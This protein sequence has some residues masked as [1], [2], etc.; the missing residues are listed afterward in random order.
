MSLNQI[1]DNGN[2]AEDWVN[3]RTHDLTVDNELKLANASIEKVD[4]T[5]NLMGAI[6]G[7]VDCE[8]RPVGKLIFVTLLQEVSLTSS[9]SSYITADNFPSEFIPTNN[10]TTSPVVV[11]DNGQQKVGS[12]NFFTPGNNI[13]FSSTN[14]NG[15]LGVF[16]GSGN[17]GF[18]GPTTFFYYL[19]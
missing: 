19:N 18:P 2:I 14:S 6:T 5:L 1:I 10:L 3:L 11:I 15:E 7:T 12:V 16:S 9:T 4:I 17:T 8:I 13:R